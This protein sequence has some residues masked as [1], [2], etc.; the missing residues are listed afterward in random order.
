M[1]AFLGSLVGILSIIYNAYA[2]NTP[3][4]IRSS[5]P[6][7]SRT[8]I[9]KLRDGVDPQSVLGEIYHDIADVHIT[10][11]DIFHSII[12]TTS[13]ELGTKDFEALAH[14]PGIEYIQADTA[15]GRHAAVQTTDDRYLARISN[16]PGPIY[17]PYH[18][19]Y[20]DSGGAGVNIYVLDGGLYWEDEEFD[21]PRVTCPYSSTP[22]SSC[23]V[24]RPNHGTWVAAIAGGKKSGVAKNANIIQVRICMTCD[25][26]DFQMADTIKGLDWVYRQNLGRGPLPPTIINYSSIFSAGNSAPIDEAFTKMVQAGYQVVVC[27]GNFGA[28]AS[29]YS[30]A[31]LPGVFTIGALNDG[32]TPAYFSNVGP[33]INYW[34]PGTSINAA[35]FFENAGTSA[36]SPIVAGIV[37]LYLSQAG[38]QLS[39]DEMDQ[40]LKRSSLTVYNDA[41]LF[42]PQVP[43]TQLYTQVPQTG[44]Q[45]HMYTH[46][47][48][49][50]N[51]PS[52]LQ[53][54]PAG[55]PA[56]PPNHQPY[57]SQPPWGL[58]F[59]RRD[60]RKDQD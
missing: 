29:K 14:V 11:S 23:T 20:P 21:S 37:A 44:G 8:W 24:D 39:H 1:R 19:A 13:Q 56:P 42:V 31:Y 45:S 59:R 52:Q 43:Q 54:H 32:D 4:P 15:I 40:L 36:S 46:L 9:I 38:R 26:T 12:L 30:P 16:G 10:H 53:I 2:V 6:H 25:S 34:A 28:D 51:R 7:I 17:P 48:R 55:H 50:Y 5:D 60:W 58:K 47:P 27:G 41:N 49:A 22:G 35:Q 33:A 3:A 57:P 18:Y